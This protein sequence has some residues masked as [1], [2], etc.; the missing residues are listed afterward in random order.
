MRLWQ[1]K[2]IWLNSDSFLPNNNVNPSISYYIYKVAFLSTKPKEAAGAV[3]A[4]FFS[5]FIDKRALPCYNGAKS[6]PREQKCYSKISNSIRRPSSMRSSPWSA[7][8]W[9][10]LPFYCTAAFSATPRR[11]TWSC[12]CCTSCTA[13]GRRDCAISIPSSPISSASF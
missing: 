6:Y 10:S 13:K 8:F 2:P 5:V 3:C 7:D 4:R 12:S 1:S 11:A 9:K